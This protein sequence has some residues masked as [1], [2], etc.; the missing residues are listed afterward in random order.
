[1]PENK[2]KSKNI[3]D[4]FKEI[5]AKMREPLMEDM[6]AVEHIVGKIASDRELIANLTGETP[7]DLRKLKACNYMK[8][9]KKLNAFLF[10]AEPDD[11]K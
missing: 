5:E 1:M 3:N 4:R 6:E 8:L 11:S 10:P 2:D 9:A 7:D